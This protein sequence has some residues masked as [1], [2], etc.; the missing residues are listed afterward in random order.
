MNNK[1]LARDVVPAMAGTHNHDR[2]TFPEMGAPAMNAQ[3][4]YYV[5]ILASRRYGTLYIGVCNDLRKRL[6]LHLLG[7]RLGIRQEVWRHATCLC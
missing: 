3:A 7:T 5:Y 1:G 6:S 2:Q 4:V